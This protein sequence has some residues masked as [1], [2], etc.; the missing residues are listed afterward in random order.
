MSAT[1]DVSQPITVSPALL[2]DASIALARAAMGSLPTSESRM[3]VRPVVCR[4]FV[5]RREELAFLNERRLAAAKS[6][7]ALV[8]VGG[9]PGIGKSR[10]LAEFYAPFVKS[11]WRVARANCLEH[12]D[13]PYGPIL[14]VLS[15]VEGA[16]VELSPEAARREQF[17]AIVARFERAAE[18]TAL[19]AVVEDVHWADVATLEL[20]AFLAPK[21]ERMRVLF[22]ASHRPHDHTFE[23]K[24]SGGLAR[25]IR[26]ARQGR[27]ELHPL[28]E[29][30][31]RAFIDDAARGYALPDATRRAVERTCEGNPLFAEELLKNAIERSSAPAAKSGVGLPSTLL[32]TLLERWHHLSV[33]D[34]RVL[35][36]AAVIGRT[37]DVEL[38]AR[39]LDLE[40]EK[41]LASL[42]RAR[43][44]QLVEPVT[45]STFRFRHALTREAVYSSFLEAQA[46][47]LH[48]TIAATLERMPEGARSLENLAYHWWAGGDGERAARYNELAGDAAGTVHAH[49]DAIAFY[50]RA[51][52]AADLGYIERGR[53]AEK[54][55][56]RCY[57]LGLTQRTHEWYGAAAT[58]FQN[59][60]DGEQ[61]ARCRTREAL[62][63]YTLRMP[64]PTGPLESMLERLESGAFLAR[65][66]VYLGVAWLQAS[67]WYPNEAARCLALVDPRALQKADL[68]LRY[69]NVAAWVAMTFG[70][71][72]RFRSEFAAWLELAEKSGRNAVALA[73]VNGSWCL[74]VFGLHE[75]AIAHV[76]QALAI[77]RSERN[78]LLEEATLGHAAVCLLMSGDLGRAR[79]ALAG[80][81]P[82]SGSFTTL[83]HATA[84]GT[85]LGIHFDDDALIARWFDE[86]SA[87]TSSTV[88][89]SCGEGLAEILVRRGRTAEAEEVLHRAMPQGERVRGVTGTLLA[90]ARF[91]APSDLAPA[92]AFLVAGADATIE[93]LEA[94]ALELFDAYVA[95]REHRRS[96]AVE[97]AR[98]AA[99]GFRR[100]RA[101]LYEAAAHEVAGDV[102]R[103]ISV[104]ARC[105]AIGDVRRLQRRAAAAPSEAAA[106][107]TSPFILSR[108]EL[109]IA[110]L[111]ARGKSNRE[112]AG[113]LAISQKTVEKHLSSAFQKLGFTS[114][115]QLAA[116]VI[117]SAE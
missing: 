6:H 70:D 111:V 108:R 93:L 67:F 38:L 101:P 106:D 83:S 40:I 43:D 110:E 17:D 114:R 25:L 105:G 53:L 10:L 86:A 77:A 55:A 23:A 52:E 29:A 115:V 56:D 96:E 109:A 3:I 95:R 66:R 16:R 49:E 107:L 62:A 98:A 61:E 88:D 37:F 51:L 82:T 2:C 30:S 15:E 91:G 76:E 47:P 41:C 33:T 81:P 104:Y 117:A 102:K 113:T 75:E 28:D 12:A 74:T 87:A 44:L 22:V 27:I 116:H 63:A 18:R 24:S 31:L 100:V 79:D 85:L 57:A 8:L 42:A 58:H 80:V 7:G 46:R 32:A 9:E 97:K 54:I 69:H 34:R 94:P 90:V 60:G 13:R 36:Q 1:D 5:G 103:A 19:L 84:S 11:H 89:P 14:D 45:I 50:E 99:E 64:N 35:A 21:L 4:S 73:H 59:A 92:R 65:S 112:I 72:E 68:A 39:T 71:L 26:S 78:R 20:L 48:R